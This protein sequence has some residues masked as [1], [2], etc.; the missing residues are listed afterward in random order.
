MK[1]PAAE[2]HQPFDLLSQCAARNK[3]A[4]IS[5]DDFLARRSEESKSSREQ[6]RPPS[7]SKSGG[8]KSKLGSWIKA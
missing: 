7:S 6:E 2:K 8:L 3:Y 5:K 4:G 1:E